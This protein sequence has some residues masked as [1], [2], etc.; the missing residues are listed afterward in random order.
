MHWVKRQERRWKSEKAHKDVL[1][2]ASLLA[3]ERRLAL[4]IDGKG[5][6]G[7]HIVCATDI[8]LRSEIKVAQKEGRLAK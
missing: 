1:I 8:M 3:A 2:E 6:D 7:D 4:I 5:N